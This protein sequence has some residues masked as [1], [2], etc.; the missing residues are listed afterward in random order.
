MKGELVVARRL[1]FGQS[2]QHGQ[3]LREKVDDAFRKRSIVVLSTQTHL[4]KVAVDSQR[5]LAVLTGGVQGQTVK[6]VLAFR[7]THGKLTHRQRTIGCIE[8]TAC[9]VGVK[10]GFEESVLVFLCQSESIRVELPDTCCSFHMRFL[11][12]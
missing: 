12:A 7:A 8:R 1:T 3:L 6:A 9:E 2:W 5:A 11:L 4:T 10:V